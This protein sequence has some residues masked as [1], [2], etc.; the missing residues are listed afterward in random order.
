[1]SEITGGNLLGGA[2]I[3]LLI[4]SL[5]LLVFMVATDRLSTSRF[6]RFLGILLIGSFASLIP[7]GFMSVVFGFPAVLLSSLLVSIFLDRD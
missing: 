1:M 4:E 2:L 7:F 3:I 6:T 5:C